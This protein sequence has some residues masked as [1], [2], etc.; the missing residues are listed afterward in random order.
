MQLFFHHLLIVLLS[1]HMLI[2]QYP[3]GQW[4]TVIENQEFTSTL[5][6]DT[7][8]DNTLII[9]A[10]FHDIEGHAL[11]LRNVSNV[12]IKDCIIYDING[13]GIALRSSGSTQNVT[14]DGCTIYNTRN[15]G[16]T[17]GQR[18]EN[19][20]DHANLVIKNNTIYNVG[21][22]EF[23]HG[24]YVQATDNL[25]ENNAVHST[26]GNGISVRSSGIIRNNTIWDTGKSCIRYYNDHAPGTSD[27]LFIENNIC[28]LTKSDLSD[29]PAI[30]LLFAKDAPINWLVQNYYV[31]FNTVVLFTAERYGFEVESPEFDDKN[32]EVY[33]NLFVNT[34]DVSKTLNTQFVDYHSSNY[35]STSLDGFVNSTDIPY[36]FHLTSTSPAR[37]YASAE[38]NFPFVD[39][40]GDQR[41]AGRLD[42]GADQLIENITSAGHRGPNKKR[43]WPEYLYLVGTLLVIALGMAIK[44]LLSSNF[45]RS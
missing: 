21:G 27:A 28:Y 16:I 23:S 6:L 40:D 19:G 11:R 38:S 24:I 1:Q 42:A 32:I 33:G 13:T 10:T 41:L 3:P 14:I 45:F 7:G 29:W 18:S 36:D 15:S 2:N 30:S 35:T 8:D 26:S 17:A 37:Y 4:D 34:E 39:I 44:K 43:V 22:D 12:Y 20:V 5:D 25:V 31:R 9:G